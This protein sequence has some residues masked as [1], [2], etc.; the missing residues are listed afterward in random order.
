MKILITGGSSYFG[1]HLVP[2]ALPECELCYT[3]YQND[4][5]ALPLGKQLDVR[6]KTAVSTLITSYHPEVIIHLAGSNRGAHMAD[7]IVQGAAHVT[8]AAAQANARLIHM[9]TDCVFDGLNPPYDETAVPTPVNEYG[10]AKAKAEA[11]VKQY[12]NHVIIRTSLIYSLEKMDQ[13]TRWMA[14]ALQRQE[15]VTLFDNQMRNPVWTT[16]LAEACLELAGSSFTGIL[17]IAGSQIMTRAEFGLKMLD[18]WGITAR[19]TMTIGPS[20]SGNW[21]L[22]L[23]FSVAK[24]TAVL[25]TPLLGVDQVLQ[26]IQKR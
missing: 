9:S 24:G 25:K 15:P 19:D 26:Q 1:Q 10:R 23:S 3:Y 2:L 8:Q 17:H 5:L 21:P 6:D 11:I 18:H 14:A 13:G 16:T 22:D 7:V 20:Q 12:P 4:P